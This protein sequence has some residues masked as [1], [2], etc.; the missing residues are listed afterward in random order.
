MQPT[1]AAGGDLT[2]RPK[3]YPGK[4]IESAVTTE[5]LNNLKMIMMC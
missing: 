2:L 3:G 1:E 5:S 4:V